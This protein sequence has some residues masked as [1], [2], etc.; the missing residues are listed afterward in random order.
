MLG[1]LPSIF[2]WVNFIILPKLQVEIYWLKKTFI[3]KATFLIVFTLI[4][5]VH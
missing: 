3:F 4:E 2:F 5:S 1:K